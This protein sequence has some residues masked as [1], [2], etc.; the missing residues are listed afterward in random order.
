MKKKVI[1]VY[2]VSLGCSK[3]FV[4]TE[5]M[6]ASLI[7]NN[8]GI[9]DDPKNASIYVIN[10]CAF[11]APARKEA[12]ENIEDAL[13]WKYSGK[14]RKIIVTGC[15]PQW[16][17]NNTYFDKFNEVDLWLG[18]DQ[19]TLL[20]DKIIELV[21]S[22]ILKENA[23]VIKNELPDFIYD[24]MTPRLQLT[25]KCY[26]FIKIAEGCD[27]RCT[28]C[29]IPDIRGSLRSRSIASICK[30][31]ENLLKNGVKELIVIAQDI[32]SFGKDQKKPNENL[33]M[34]LKELDNLPGNFW[35]RLHYLHPEG[36]TD[37][38]IAQIKN[39]KHVIPYLDIPIQHI[40]DK[41]LKLMNRKVMSDHIKNVL[42]KLKKEIP[43]IVIRTTFIVGFPSETEKDFDELVKFV[44]EFK[45][46]RMGVFPYYPEEGTPAEKLLN[47]IAPDIANKR[48]D[49]ILNIH[50]ENSLNFNKQLVGKEYDVIIDSVTENGALGRTYMDSPD[51]DNTFNIKK[52]PVSKECYFV[53]AKVTKADFFNLHGV[54]R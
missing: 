10:T 18:I 35:I 36:I 13:N 3:N 45:F 34:L 15:L 47:Q 8:I 23:K 48:A 31:A 17:K 24:D 33:C 44:K 29:S 37:E 43:E 49:I 53:K 21:S 11:I 26:S 6:A 1:Y 38:L 46:E 22:T 51:I 7:K 54:L 5:V 2:F 50:K 30:E 4:D 9:T 19:I 16:D 41:I 12:E 32:T 25:P 27:N 28:Y 20:A 40:S 52:C 14:S 42:S 39:S